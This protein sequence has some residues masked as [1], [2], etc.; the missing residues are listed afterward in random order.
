MNAVDEGIVPAEGNENPQQ[1]ENQPADN[2]AWT[3]FLSGFPTSMHDSIKPHL[4]RWDEGVNQRISQVHSEYADFKP[5]RDAGVSN[6]V[7]QQAY[8]VFQAL[9]DNPQEV[10]RILGETYGY[11]NQQPQNAPTSANPQQGQVNPQTN[12]PTGDEYG[13]GEGGQFNPEVAR[14]KAM[15]ENM[16]QIM[17]AQ[18]NAR[19]QAAEDAALDSQLK[20]AREK[21]G[22][23]NEKFVLGMVQSGESFEGAIKAYQG[24]V[25]QIRSDA[26]RPAA[27][28]VLNGQGTGQLPSQQVDPTKL[29][30]SERRELVAQ[31]FKASNQQG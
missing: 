27:P 28:V 15:T 2:P 21:H 9:N 1:T 12:Q 23:F 31:M 24:L 13:I 22:D 19:Q 10:Y 25:N 3:D 30:P 16:A 8:G 4:S 7:L 11:A 26:N 18:E 6:E 20:A 29:T 5:W 14:L 17:V